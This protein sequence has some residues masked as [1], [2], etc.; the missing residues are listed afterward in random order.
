MQDAA[1]ARFI[2]VIPS[3]DVAVEIVDAGIVETDRRD[4]SV[5]V[6]PVRKPVAAEIISP[7]AIAK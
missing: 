7:G 3:L 6:E 4:H 5:A 2:D 1:G